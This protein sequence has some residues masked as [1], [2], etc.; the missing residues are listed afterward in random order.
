[1]FSYLIYNSKIWTDL[2]NKTRLMRIMST[3]AVLYILIHSFIN[4]KYVENN[5][6]VNQYKKYFYFIVSLDY[7]IL[8]YMYYNCDN[9]KQKMKKIK[10]DGNKD[11]NNDNKIKTE[12]S[13]IG[14]VQLPIYE[15]KDNDTIPIYDNQKN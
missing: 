5:D 6:F 11:E 8:G 7:A 13:D 9:V 15:N 3:T 1:M 2:D 10:Q 14:S 12:N 4:S